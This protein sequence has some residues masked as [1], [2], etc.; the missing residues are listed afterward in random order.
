MTQL[1]QVVQKLTDQELREVQD[2]AEFLLA[3]RG[4]AGTETTEPQPIRY[5]RW[6]GS[7]A[8]V[9]PEMSDAEFKNL[10]RDEWVRTAED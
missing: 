2:F 4:Q 1:L 10:I 9:H 3:R 7:L 6:F 5:G 8:H